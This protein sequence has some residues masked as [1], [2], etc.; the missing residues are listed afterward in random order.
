MIQESGQAKVGPTLRLFAG[1][2]VPAD[3][4]SAL[5]S[6]VA[7]IKPL[8]HIR[9]SPASNFHITTK[10]IGAWPKD[11]LSE[12]KV[13]LATLQASGAFKLAVRG[14][15][16]LPNA[17]R[18]R[19]FRVGIESDDGGSQLASLASRTDDACA[20][21]GV[22]REKKPYSPHLTLAR[23]NS[24]SNLAALHEGLA[25]LP[26]ADFGEFEAT[27]FHLYQSQ[28]G[29]DGSIYTSLAEFPL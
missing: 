29:R 12:V 3:V 11:R 2:A 22:E 20:K 28:P 23:I 5:A 17:K 25:K 14:L 18:P 7:R 21:L 26:A 19:I 16:F 27:V 6:F 4:S 24:P 8:A 10:F 9:W 13:A 15:G 1:I